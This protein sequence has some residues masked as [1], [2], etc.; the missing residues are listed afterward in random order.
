MAKKRGGSPASRNVMRQIKLGKET[1]LKEFPV[2]NEKVPKSVLPYISAGGSRRRRRRRRTRK[3][4]SPL[5]KSVQAIVN[6][7]SSSS[8]R[9]PLDSFPSLSNYGT[10]KNTAK[11]PEIHSGQFRAPCNVMGNLESN[12]AK[13]S[14]AVGGRR[15][16]RT[17]KSKRS[18]RKRRS[19]RGG[20]AFKATLY[21]WST[22]PNYQKNL[23]VFSPEAVQYNTTSSKNVN[24]T[25]MFKPFKKGGR[26]RLRKSKRLRRKRRSKRGGSDFKA[27]LYSWSTN[28]NYQKNLNVFSPD[29]VQYS[30]TS[31]KNVNKTVMFKPFKKGGRRRSI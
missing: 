18:R 11:I 13:R 26:K 4:G 17:R 16:R 3:G 29:A 15:R 9:S 12:A 6:N 30:P 22:N 1:H 7:L 21:S 23:N 19:K 24:K 8:H 25:V 28:P 10:N 14:Q 5:S 20:S 2:L 31:S 27:T